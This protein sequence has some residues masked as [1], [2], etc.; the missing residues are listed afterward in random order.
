M[1]SFRAPA[2]LPPPRG[3]HRNMSSYV[4]NFTATLWCKRF[5]QQLTDANEG[6]VRTTARLLQKEHVVMVS[7]GGKQWLWMCFWPWLISCW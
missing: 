6:W 3:R 1:L 7:A 2:P 4:N 5:V